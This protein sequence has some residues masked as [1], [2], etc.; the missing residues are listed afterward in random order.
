LNNEWA[1]LFQA[2]LIAHGQFVTTFGTATSQHLA[3]IGS[4]HALSETMNGFAA[5][6]MRLKCTFHA[7]VFKPLMNF[8]S[9]QKRVHHH[10]FL[11]KDRKSR[12]K[13][14]KTGNY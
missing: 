3:A 4:L 14:G 2:F 8:F 1:L 11:R 12:A 5:F 6:A 9:V 10:T 13:C 7:F